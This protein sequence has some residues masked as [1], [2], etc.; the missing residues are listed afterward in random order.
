MSLREWL[1]DLVFPPKCV[2]C[3][4]ILESAGETVC[5]D[6]RKSLPKYRCE[7]AGKTEFIPK[8]AAALYYEDTVRRSLHR[9]KF[10]GRSHYAPVYAALMWEA[11]SAQLDAPFDTLSYVPLSRKRLRQRGYD[12]ARLLAEELGKILGMEP[13]PLLEKRRDVPAQS[14]M[15]TAA[16][17]RANISGCYAVTADVRGRRILLVDDIFTTGATLSEAAR[18]LRTA[19]AA[20]VYAAAVACVKTKK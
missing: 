20:E 3:T 9:Y 19:G 17:R 2:F 15:K 8:V 11:V 10:S 18:M 14:S 7:R 6:C 4:A 5:P 1:L 12:Q 13:V 16:E